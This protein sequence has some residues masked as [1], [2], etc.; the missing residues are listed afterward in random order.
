MGSFHCTQCGGEFYL[1]MRSSYTCPNCNLYLDDEAK[2]KT[3]TQLV[4]EQ[5]ERKKTNK[6]AVKKLQQVRKK[7]KK[8]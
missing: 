7:A 1:P 8:K 6:K 5:V 2:L 4:T 3:P